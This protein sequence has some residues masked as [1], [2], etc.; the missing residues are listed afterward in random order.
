MYIFKRRL[1][2]PAGI[3]MP[4][5]RRIPMYIIASALMV[6]LPRR[7]PRLGE[8]VSAWARKVEP[9]VMI[10][11]VCDRDW[12]QGRPDVSYMRRVG[13]VDISA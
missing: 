4:H 7:A 5:R 8:C 1:Q 6:G 11:V 3:A 10:S 12:C 2:G 9:G 13:G